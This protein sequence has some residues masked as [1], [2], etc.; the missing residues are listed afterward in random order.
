MTEKE[1]PTRA[2][3]LNSTVLGIGVASLLADSGHEMATAAL[4][5]FLASLGASSAIL[6]VIEGLSD[7]FASFAKLFSGA[8][9]D[10]LRSRKPLAVLGYFLTA[11]GM[12]S[13]A[14]ATNAWHVLAGRIAGWIGRGAR[15]PVKNVLL[16]EATT[17]DTYGRAF[18]LE[19][20]M[21][22]AGAVL[23]PLVALGLLATLGPRATFAL[24]LI[25]G[26]GAAVA[27]VFLVREKPHEPG[28]G[29]TLFA[30]VKELPSAYKRFL[31][32][33]GVA[34]LG[35]Y[36]NTLLILF[37]TQAWTPRF[38]AGRA[39]TFAM[40]G[41]VGYNVV[42]TISCWIAGALA[43]RFPKQLV[44]SFGYALA[45]V[46]AVALM[47]P[48]DSIAKFV[49][50]FGMSGL[51]MGFWETVESTTAATLLPAKNSGMGFGVLATVNGVGDLASSVLVGAL[52]AGS[53]QLAM[54][55]VIA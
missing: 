37:A 10:R 4:P 16:K 34:G 54:G 12:A 26:V 47:I 28:P 48:G 18:G 19:R 35:D 43:D 52:W 53:P 23:G 15:S 3:W 13:F 11:S 30:G 41:Y 27:I 21:D 45:V 2:R 7:G 40:G 22:S 38:G 6:G 42:Y 44:L 39:A 5:A 36:S 33:V 14:L 32:G 24:T 46:P 51:Y 1:R 20:A 31:A 55:F 17:P 8:Y 25:P 50:A 9:S 29:R 49:V